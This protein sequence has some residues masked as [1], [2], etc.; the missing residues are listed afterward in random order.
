MTKRRH[1]DVI[2][3]G[4]FFTKDKVVLG[5]VTRSEAE[6][7]IKTRTSGIL[8]GDGFTFKIEAHK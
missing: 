5:N 4:S 1:V 2:M 3:M 6:A 8:L 7:Y